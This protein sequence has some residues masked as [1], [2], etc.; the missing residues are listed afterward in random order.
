M[1]VSW[2]TIQPREFHFLRRGR[3]TAIATRQDKSLGNRW[4]TEAGPIVYQAAM[5]G[6]PARWVTTDIFCDGGLSRGA[7]KIYAD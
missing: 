4:Q 1:G 6:V 5:K 3:C 7:F 2:V